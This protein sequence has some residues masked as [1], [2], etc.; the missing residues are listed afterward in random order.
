MSLYGGQQDAVNED[1]DSV[2]S[3]SKRK[4][5]NLQLTE[6]Y[7]AGS[8]E[9]ENT[10]PRMR[11]ASDRTTPSKLSSVSSPQSS[12]KSAASQYA[13]RRQLAANWT[14]EVTGRN[15]GASSDV[16]F[17]QALQGG[18]ALCEALNVVQPGSVQQVA[19]GAEADSVPAQFNAARRNLSAFTEGAVALGLLAE[20][21]P[22]LDD[23]TA[24]W[25]DPHG[26]E[27]PARALTE[28]LLALRQLSKSPSSTSI[29]PALL[30]SQQLPAQNPNNPRQALTS[31]SVTHPGT[32]SSPQVARS[33]CG[34][35]PA[36]NGG[37]QS[38]LPIAVPDTIAAPPSISDDAGGLIGDLRSPGMGA[39]PQKAS[40]PQPSLSSAGSESI[41]MNTFHAQPASNSMQA[42]TFFAS[43]FSSGQQNGWP[44]PN[45][46]ALGGTAG[47]A[48]PY[49]QAHRNV[50][51]REST[52]SPQ[53][54]GMPQSPFARAPFL[55]PSDSSDMGYPSPDFAPP[56]FTAVAKRIANGGAS[57]F[58]GAQSY[59]AGSA[60]QGVTRLMQQCTAML[61]ERMGSDP[62]AL[63]QTA[64]GG[65]PRPSSSTALACAPSTPTSL[66]RREDRAPSSPPDTA[67]EAMGPVLESVLGSLTQ[68]YEKR[69]LTKD[70]EVK[71]SAQ[72]VMALQAELMDAKEALAEGSRCLPAPEPSP[73]MTDEER[74]ELEEMRARENDLREHLE[75]LENSLAA[76]HGEQSSQEAEREAIQRE[77]QTLQ[78]KVQELQAVADKYAGT[79]EE[80]RRLYNEVQ[81]LKGNIRVF[82][83]IRPLG[84]TGDSS[85]GCTEVG[86][87]GEVAVYNPSTRQR[88]TFKYDRVFGPESSQAEVYEDTKA[89][90]RSVLDGYNVCIFAYGQTGSGKT[91]T[92]AGTHVEDL[93][94]RGINYRALDDLFELN[95]RRQ[96]EVEYSIRV[97]LLEIYNEQLRDLLDTSRAPKKLN[98]QNTERSGLNVPDAIQVE[99]TCTEDVLSV[100]DLG[101]SNRAVAETKMNERS[102]RSHSVLTI[103]VDGHSHVTGGRTHGCLHL[104]D[105]AGSERVG[106]SE[107]TGDR[108]EEAKHINKSLSALGDVMSALAAKQNHIPFRNSKLTQLLQDS[109]CG[110]AKAMT[111]VHVAP[112]VS[113]HGESVSTLAFGSRVSEVTLGQ[114]KKNSESGR[115]F[116][117]KEAL[118]RL[119]REAGHARSEAA[120]MREEMEMTR[121]A[122]QDERDAMEQE[123]A[124]L[125]MEL[126]EARRGQSSRASSPSDND[127][128]E[129]HRS[130]P[131]PVRT[132]MSPLQSRMSLDLAA[133]SS[134]VG[135][136][137]SFIKAV[138]SSMRSTHS[139]TP[140]GSPALKTN[141]L[142]RS[143]PGVASPRTLRPPTVPNIALKG[144]S[145]ADHSP[146]RSV[147]PPT[148]ARSNLPTA[149][150]LRESS[151]RPLTSRSSMATARELVGRMNT[152]RGF[153][154]PLTARE[155][156]V[157]PPTAVRKAVGKLPASTAQD[158]RRLTSGRLGSENLGMLVSRAGLSEAKRVGTEPGSARSSISRTAS[159]R[160]SVDPGQG[161]WM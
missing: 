134:P 14:E 155:S 138:P 102:S 107:A 24:A 1:R 40:A 140:R 55:S 38:L 63:Q 53:V 77:F 39:S 123:M 80:N 137:S 68:E 159:I 105:L 69:L 133:I 32:P 121:Q 136:S 44:G 122:A 3:A 125:K 19:E 144:Q 110:Q 58:G 33:E 26:A 60:A 35:S 152:P 83:R 91:H 94:G 108:L 31:S 2:L 135:S 5:G 70:Q 119:E 74:E 28:C 103:I 157:K 118:A 79:I 104:I 57:R 42:P 6:V 76:R 106:K 161:R 16:A 100:M 101:Q 17:W 147:N 90:I 131:A 111:F 88:R 43:S 20:C 115:V 56:G 18:E 51:F 13:E 61:R 141:L 47:L 86:M 15:V 8:G 109:L 50:G 41:S 30:Y 52:P 112:E 126:E 22:A 95:A 59:G 46:S 124:Q 12:F 23:M 66:M 9:K 114:A 71:A 82:C 75:S 67:L 25:E 154:A 150:S 117:A 98:I 132:A 78:D 148:S 120:Q 99:V 97:Q 139:P 151:R 160:K 93:A 10:P 64:A 81:D 156:N 62:G 54:M 27:A 129:S 7:T 84:K 37:P 127:G 65:A 116:E 29:H 128:G 85:A 4:G 72:R 73:G 21:L 113:S 36:V 87:E 89:L 145:R 48:L 142:G 146:A 130:Y 34:E 153:E 45:S 143:S 149:A 49:E 11:A 96:E 158:A 92:M